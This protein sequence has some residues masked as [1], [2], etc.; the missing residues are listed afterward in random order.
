MNGFYG[1][2]LY[3]DLTN[4]QVNIEPI[5][6]DI[7][8]RYLGGKGLA[9]YLLYRHN[10]PGINPLA[11]ENRL[12]FATGPVTGSRIW[13]SCR[14]GVFSKSPKPASTASPMPAAG[15]PKPLMPVVLTPWLSAVKAKIPSF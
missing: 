8:Q 14:Y 3:L 5:P 12:V 9:S 13:G 10:P 1:R 6:E 4:Q 2:I 15:F 11:P 7:L